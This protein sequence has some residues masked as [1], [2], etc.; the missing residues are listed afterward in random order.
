MEKSF[1]QEKTTLKNQYQ[2][3]EKKE[4]QKVKAKAE[5]QKHDLAQ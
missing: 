4:V 5:T 1:D 2:E 3:K